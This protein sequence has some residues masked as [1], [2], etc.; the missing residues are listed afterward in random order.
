MGRGTGFRRLAM[1]QTGC[2]RTRARLALAATAMIGAG[3]ASLPW[4]ER[5]SRGNAVGW[6][7]VMEKV[8]PAYLVALDRSECVVTEKRWKKIDEGDQVF[9]AWHRTHLAGAH[10]LRHDR[11]GPAPVGAREPTARPRTGSRPPRE[12]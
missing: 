3:C 8:P 11:V 9:C 10:M 5:G 1:L 4:G 6:K 7:M 12:R 2:W